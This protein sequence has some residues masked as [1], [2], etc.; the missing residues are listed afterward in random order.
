[1]VSKINGMAFDHS[2]FF[3]I[4]NKRNGKKNYA[5]I[6]PVNLPLYSCS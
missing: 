4:N 3:L 5:E 1:M 6:H 2:S